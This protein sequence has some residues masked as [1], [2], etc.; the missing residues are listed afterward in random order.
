MSR[1]VVVTGLSCITPLGNSVKESWSN[2]L[3][4]VSGLVPITSL[5]SYETYYKP[6]QNSFPPQLHV[7]AIDINRSSDLTYL[8]KKLFTS[9]DNRRMTPLIKNSILSTHM[10]LQSANLLSDMSID[11]MNNDLDRISISIGVGLPPVNEI[12]QETLPFYNKAKK[13][14]PMVIPQILPSMVASAMSIKYGIRGPTQVLSSACSTGNNAIIDG[15]NMIQN[16]LVDIAIV[17]ASEASLHPLTLAG[18]NRLK[19][20]SIDS[21]SRPFDTRR[22][23]FIMS[24]GYGT[25][26]L[27][28]YEHAMRRN[29]NI[30]ATVEN[31]GITSDA[32][33][34]TM[35]R[36][37]SQGVLKAMDSCLQR[38]NVKIHE[39][40]F[41][42]AHATSTLVGD[43][44]ELNG[45]NKLLKLNE[46]DREHPLYVTSNKGAM[47]HLLG[48]AGL[49]E[50]IFTILSLRERIIPHTLNLVDP[51]SPGTNSKEIESNNQVRNN[52]IHL[53]KDQPIRLQ[54]LKYGLCNSFGFG[55]INTSI[56]YSNI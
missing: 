6:F 33:H 51:I 53:V 32:F 30:W 52:N 27:E 28:D 34:M 19:S 5:P 46:I 48:A 41:I 49:V 47:G 21:V 2:L 24:E 10:A 44:A 42:S 31:F 16:D 3:N 26:I 50:S 54:S 43:Q 1:K 37:D 7:G 15:L 20:L 13:I 39:L 38:S 36:R 35:P 17:G 8:S 23:G 40:D 55:G 22:D 9:Q 56:L 11:Q 45:I 18:F 29:A 12:V 14:S 4:S 25:I